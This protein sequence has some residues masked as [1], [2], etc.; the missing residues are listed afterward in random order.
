MKSSF[1]YACQ[2]TL[3]VCKKKEKKVGSVGF[4]CNMFDPA[5]A[6][7]CHAVTKLCGFKV[8]WA[9]LC[10]FFSLESL[11]RNFFLA[12]EKLGKIDRKFQHYLEFRFFICYC[13]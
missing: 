6:K 1:M 8:T 13:Q 4:K 12:H 10:H 7:V 3:R 9:E 11:I 5:R 2:C